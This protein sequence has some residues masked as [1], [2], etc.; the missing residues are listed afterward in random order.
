MSPKVIE[1]FLFERRRSGVRNRSGGRF[2]TIPQMFQES[3][4]E[5]Q[6]VVP[7]KSD[8][9]EL[10]KGILIGFKFEFL[11]KRDF[12]K[13]VQNADGNLSRFAPKP[14]RPCGKRKVSDTVLQVNMPNF[15][16]QHELQFRVV[17]REFDQTTIQKNKPTGQRGRIDV[18]VI[19]QFEV[20]RDALSFSAIQQRL[21]ESLVV[22]VAIGPRWMGRNDDGTRR[23]DD[24]NDFVRL[25]VGTA[26]ADPKTRVIPV[27]CEGARIPGEN[28]RERNA[29]K[30]SPHRS[31]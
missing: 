18:A 16:S 26:L 17:L 21:G 29:R 28:R 7:R 6:G 12:I 9:H 8:V 30:E 14:F 10:A 4:R 24:P 31:A 3:S 13:L 1:D 19:N 25:E 27:L 22:L 15:M 5:P 20:V 23:I 11:R 2:T